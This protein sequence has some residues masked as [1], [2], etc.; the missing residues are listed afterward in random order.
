MKIYPRLKTLL[1]YVVSR[2]AWE[3]DEDDDNG[4]NGQLRAS[5]K[6]LATTRASDGMRGQQS[7]FHGILVLIGLC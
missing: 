6:P 2:E 1:I 5:H 3:M 7:E 4:T